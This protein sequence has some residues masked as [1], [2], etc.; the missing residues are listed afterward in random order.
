[1]H[2][3]SPSKAPQH[4][5][6]VRVPRLLKE[7]FGE[8]ITRF[9]LWLTIGFGVA[10]SALLLAVTRDEWRMIAPW[11]QLALVVLTFDVG[12]G[13]LGTLTASTNRYYRNDAKARLTFILS[14]VQ[15]VV[16][17]FLLDSA[18]LVAVGVTAYTVVTALVVNA[19]I[20]HPAQRVI[21]ASF[22]LAGVTV[23]LL[24][25]D[26]VPRI[27]MALSALYMFKVIYG[28]AVDHDAGPAG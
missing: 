15:P 24:T 28:F 4:M 5:G 2:T 21:G 25:I 20:G 18:Y 23:L 12:G 22:M 10:V 1:M 6:T 7:L 13:V 19:L 8:R 11:R 3:F 9:E 17:A 27:L 14:H 26:G 16:L